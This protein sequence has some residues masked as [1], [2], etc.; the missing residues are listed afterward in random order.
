MGAAAACLATPAPMG[1]SES[2]GGHSPLMGNMAPKRPKP[3]KR[4]QQPPRMHSH[5]GTAPTNNGDGKCPD[6]CLARHSSNTPNT[7]SEYRAS[8]N[9][10]QWAKPTGSL[11]HN[12]RLA[13]PRREGHEPKSPAHATTS[14]APTR[15]KHPPPRQKPALA[16]GRPDAANNKA[17]REHISKPR[18]S[19]LA[20]ETCQIVYG[21]F[22]YKTAKAMPKRAQIQGGVCKRTGW[23]DRG[24]HRPR[25]KHTTQGISTAVV[26]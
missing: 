6:T 2:D 25:T 21:Q 22:A 9:T 8:S 16:G 15:A 5:M 23:E 18:D 1:Q 14:C 10:E 11:E 19:A 24:V 3:S 20:Q 13:R 12:A 7:T 17:G 4:Q 26:I